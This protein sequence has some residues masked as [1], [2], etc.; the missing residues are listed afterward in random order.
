MA[1]LIT[2]VSIVFLSCMSS[3]RRSTKTPKP[4]V[5]GLC[6]RNPPVTGGFQSERPSKAENVFIWWQY[7]VSNPFYHMVVLDHEYFMQL[8][9]T[10][11]Y[12]CA[13]PVLYFTKK[14]INC[15]YLKTSQ[16]KESAP[17]WKNEFQATWWIIL[18]MYSV[19][20]DQFVPHI[21]QCS[22]C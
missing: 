12:T 22:L 3:W 7:H 1:S 9:W 19:L 16:V 21:P 13:G 6:E 17:Y 4:R 10:Y 18:S 5:T 15:E 8:T 20:Q 11:P 14:G 2:G